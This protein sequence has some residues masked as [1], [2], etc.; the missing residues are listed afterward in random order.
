MG[1]ALGAALALGGILTLGL[2]LPWGERFP[3]WMGPLGGTPVPA[4][5]AVTPALVVSALFTFGGVG[6]AVDSLR[7]LPP[8]GEASWTIAL[9]L[10]FWLW[11]PL[12]AL[13]TWGY[14]LHRR[15]ADAPLG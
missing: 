11:G 12:L 15:A 8:L 14:A 9:V 3:A 5:L 2:I 6:L 10:P 1:L 4:W 13:S 7:G